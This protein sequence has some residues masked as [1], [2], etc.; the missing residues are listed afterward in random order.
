MLISYRIGFIILSLLV[1]TACQPEAE[2][3]KGNAQ[4]TM[5]KEIASGG[6]VFEGEYKGQP[7]TI[8]TGNEYELFMEVQ[9]AFN[10]MDAE[11]IWQHSADTVAY[12]TS[13]GDMVPLTQNYM[14]EFFNSADSLSWDMLSVIPVHVENSDQVFILVDSRE[15]VYNKNGTVNRSKLFERFEFKNDKIVAVYQWVAN[16]ESDQN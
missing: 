6:N 5:Q 9:K 10:N 4:D 7:F 13:S 2:Q 12:R 16:Q 15:V 8:A 11:A 14:A 1:I 3:Q